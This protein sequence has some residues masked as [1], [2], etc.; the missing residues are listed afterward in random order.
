MVALV[1]TLAHIKID[2]SGALLESQSQLQPLDFSITT[3][4]RLSKEQGDPSTQTI[5][6]LT[7]KHFQQPGQ[8][9]QV[10]RVRNTLSAAKAT[11]QQQ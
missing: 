7:G 1:K 8:P 11:A 4:G 2:N 6:N 5:R 3:I 10:Q 9:T